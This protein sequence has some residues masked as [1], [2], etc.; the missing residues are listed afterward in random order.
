MSERVKPRTQNSPL[1]REQA[2]ITRARIIEA[3]GVVFAASGYD[4]ARIEDIAKQ[5]GVAYPTVY[6]AFSN[7]PALLGAAVAAAMSGSEHDQVERQTWWL[8]QLDEPDPERQLRLIARNARRIYDRAGRLLE[9][10]RAAAAGDDAIHAL[11]QTVN[12]DRLERSHV[13]AK[14]LA[15]KTAL[16]TTANETARTLWAL[17]GPELYVLQTEAGTATPNRYERWLADLLVAALLPTAS[18]RAHHRRA[19]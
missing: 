15:S 4:R 8:E 9:V 14:R 7:K 12:D 13:S 5:A 2:A 1:R 6:K 19:Q 10:V 3:A 16:A 11:W 18:R 17:T